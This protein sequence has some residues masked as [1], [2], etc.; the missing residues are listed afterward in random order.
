MVA[1]LP[2]LHLA[3]SAEQRL[4]GGHPWVYSNELNAKAGQLGLAA[5]TLVELRGAREAVL[6]LGYFNPATLIA[7]RVLDRRA[8]VAIDRDF[9]AQRLARARQLRC[10]LGR[11][12]FGRQ[13]HGEADGLPG[14]IL[15]RYDD[16]LVGQI[17][18]AG[19]E[20]R[21]AELV[22]AIHA[23]HAPAALLWKSDGAGRA[24]E[25]LAEETLLPAGGRPVEHLRV[26]EGALRF[27][28]PLAHAQK[29]GWFYDQRDNRDRVDALLGVAIVGQSMLDI[30][31]YQ[32]GWA[33]R[34]L[35][36][37]AAHA[38]CVDAS[39]DAL[40]GCV[41]NAGLN[42]I[43]ATRLQTLR[44]AA[45]DVLRELPDDA[46]FGLVVA[47]PPA[48]I[49]RRKDAQAGAI[50][51]ARLFAAAMRRVQHGGYL[52]ACSCSHHYPAEALLDALRDAAARQRRALR[53]LAELAQ[54]VDHPV[55]PALPETRYLKG[56]LCALD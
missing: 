22:A 49:K 5:G 54:G 11:G 23:V 36:A 34:A 4:R 33:L 24:L 32:G 10:D 53:V 39:A 20:V 41:H 15:D 30:C 51:Y 47:D 1:A 12:L 6:G 14:L 16:V 25:G 37:G 18:T 9:F 21:K 50:A 28:I 8:N 27:E 2:V 44:G 17:G 52:V 55:H 7:V 3:R 26:Q 45:M 35:H 42:G 19:L 46:R 38:T 13:V 40:A 56:L 29:T 31:S 48:F 43:A